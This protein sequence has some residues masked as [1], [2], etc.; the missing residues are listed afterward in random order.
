MAETWQAV[1]IVLA[2]LIFA[3][4]VA[5]LTRLFSAHK[6]EG[7]TFAMV[8]LGVAGVVSIAGFRIGWETVGF[9]V[10]CFAVA[11]L[12]MGIEYYSRFI[13]EQKKANEEARR[14]L[15]GNSGTNR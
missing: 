15:D 8:V 1:G 7:Q 5:W 9:L 12:P 2:E 11:A 6:I 10:L 13:A 4:G 3:S 14:I